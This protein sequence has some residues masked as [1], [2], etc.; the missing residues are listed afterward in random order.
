MLPVFNAQKA[1]AQEKESLQKEIKHPLIYKV[2]KEG[3]T[4]YLF[5]SNHFLSMSVIPQYIMDI[6]NSCEILLSENPV[7]FDDLTPIKLMKKNNPLVAFF[8]DPK[9]KSYTDLFNKFLTDI[10]TYLKDLKIDAT[11][12]DLNPNFVMGLFKLKSCRLMSEGFAQLFKQNNKEIA[13]VINAEEYMEELNQ[14]SLPDCERKWHKFA[15]F[16]KGFY[17]SSGNHFSSERINKIYLESDVELIS[18]QQ[19]ED[20]DERYKSAFL[21]ECKKFSEGFISQHQKAG[22]KK[23]FFGVNYGT[24]YGIKQNLEAQGFTVSKVTKGYSMSDVVRGIKKLVV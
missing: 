13:S 24:I 1:R 2:T 16:L 15:G 21:N 5:G 19:Y 3:K 10:N 7:H 8:R 23:I 6:M 20:M 17:S 14:A 12:E 11:V 4:H 22:H 9:N 18:P